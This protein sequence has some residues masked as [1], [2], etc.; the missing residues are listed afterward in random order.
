[1]TDCQT[2]IQGELTPHALP[3]SQMTATRGLISKKVGIEYNRM[4]GHESY[5][6]H[7]PTWVERG[8]NM[9]K[10]KWMD[11]WGCIPGRIRTMS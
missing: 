10:M 9:C 7:T 8:V 5:G 4:N 1:V 6:T 3:V 2:C 11:G